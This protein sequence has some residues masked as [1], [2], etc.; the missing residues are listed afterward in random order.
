MAVFPL[1]TTRYTSNKSAVLFLVRTR[2]FKLWFAWSLTR[3]SHP[4][5]SRP[6]RQ[7][8]RAPPLVRSDPRNSS[9]PCWFQL[10]CFR[11]CGFNQPL[12]GCQHRRIKIKN[13]QWVQQVPI[14]PDGFS[15]TPAPVPC[16]TQIDYRNSFDPS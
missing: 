2:N 9:V 16:C 6:R 11:S 3:I 12:N 1:K 15:P 10:F 7:A 8:Y 13:R 14:R 4:S 5:G